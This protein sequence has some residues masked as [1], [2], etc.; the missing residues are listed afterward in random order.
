MMETRLLELTNNAHSSPV[1]LVK[2]H[3]GTWRFCVDYQTLNDTMIKDKHPILVIDELLDELSG[4]RY[5]SKIDLWVE[6]HQTRMA[7][8]DVAK[9]KFWMLDGHCEFLVMSFGLT[10]SPATFQWCMDDIFR[11]T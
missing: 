8:D 7:R 3:D 4:A 6:Y 9:T 10:N 1:L 5:F 11:A 2:K